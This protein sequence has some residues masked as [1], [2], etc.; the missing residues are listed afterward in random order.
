MAYCINWFDLF[1]YLITAH[2]QIEQILIS[3]SLRA[4]PHCH[5]SDYVQQLVF[6]C[7]RN[8]IILQSLTGIKPERSI[9]KGKV[10]LKSVQQ[11]HMCILIKKKLLINNLFFLRY[12]VYCHSIVQ[13]MLIKWPFWMCQILNDVFDWGVSLCHFMTCDFFL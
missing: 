3:S 8:T 7:S 11:T 12:C 13:H 6:T 9:D 5:S 4:I 1:A 2:V 10:E